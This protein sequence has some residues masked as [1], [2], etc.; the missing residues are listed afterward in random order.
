MRSGLSKILGL[1]AVLACAI[2][3]DGEEPSK[4]QTVL[5][6]TSAY[7][8]GLG[9]IIAAKR[10][11]IIRQESQWIAAFTLKL[12]VTLLITQYFWALPLGEYV[13]SNVP[14]AVQDSNIYD[15]DAAILNSDHWKI[16]G[17]TGTWQSWGI[18][19]YIASIYLI[20]GT[21]V[22]YVAVF[23]SILSLLGYLALTAILTRFDPRNSDYWQFLRWGMLLPYGAYYD[24]TPAKEALTHAAFYIALYF[25]ARLFIDKKNRTLCGLGFAA[26]LLVLALARL[27]VMVLLLLIA[28]IV[29]LGLDR[30]NI[31]KKLAVVGLLVLG[32]GVFVFAQSIV[33]GEGIEEAGQRAASYFRTEDYAEISSTTLQERQSGGGDADKLRIVE[34]LTPKGWADGIGLAPVRTVLWLY[35]PY[36]L[37]IPDFAAMSDLGVLLAA[38]YKQFVL[39]TEGYFSIAGAWTL[40]GLAPGLVSLFLRRNQLT[41]EGRRRTLFLLI[42]LLF[43]AIVIPNVF[44]LNNRRYR[45]LIEPLILATS[46]WGSARFATGPVKL[47]VWSCAAAGLATPFFFRALL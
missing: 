20:F 47:W 23:N 21:S 42:P 12:V 15:L 6:L 34:F 36:P 17:I 28:G 31:E 8:L 24:A 39:T 41:P 3:W 26:S 10:Y 4:L 9:I 13:R 32:L 22:A 25:M 2:W 27:N 30:R 35:G 5:A 43:V 38:D 1:C 46:L 33:F 29:L 18:V 16:G 45:L 37:V 40:I 19:R 7:L 11:Q 44:I 14:N